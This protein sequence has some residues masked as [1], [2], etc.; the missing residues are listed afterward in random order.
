MF[1]VSWEVLIH[2]FATAQFTMEGLTHFITGK[3]STLD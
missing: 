3:G 2:F 1:T